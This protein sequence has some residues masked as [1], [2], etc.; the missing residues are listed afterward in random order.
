M[1]TIGAFA[2]AQTLTLQFAPKTGLTGLRGR[3]ASSPTLPDRPADRPRRQLLR[4]RHH[5]LRGYTAAAGPWPVG[6]AT[7]HD[8]ELPEKYW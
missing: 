8:T 3:L 6:K 5:W 7:L 1:Q 4:L 2:D